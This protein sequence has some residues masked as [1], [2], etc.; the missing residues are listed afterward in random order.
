[1]LYSDRDIRVLLDTGDIKIFPAPDLTAQLGSCSLDL[2][3]GHEFSVFDYSRIPYIDTRDRSQA[4]QVTKQIKVEEDQH[5]ILQPGAFVL[6]VTLET[7]ELNDN[8]V[9]RLEGRSSLGRLGIVVHATASI[10]DPG[11]RGRIVLELGNHGTMPVAL[12]PQ[13]RICSL[14]FES[15]S[16]R[17]LVPYGDKSNAKYI[18]Q[19]SPLS[20]RIA[21]D[22]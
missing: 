21:D 4:H 18:S 22:I 6:A 14:T 11:W 2:R 3:L 9:A 16:S 8:V 5:F 17:V 20:S 7:V 1:M 15:L 19:N 10:I 13:M 12:Y